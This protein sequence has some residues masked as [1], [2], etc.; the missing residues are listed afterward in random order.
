MDRR[1]SDRRASAINDLYVFDVQGLMQTLCRRKIL[2]IGI[3]L[4]LLA[5]ALTFVA[6]KPSQYRAVTSVIIE[7]PQLNPTEFQEALPTGRFDDLTI[8]TQVK[9]ISSPTIAHLT[10]DALSGK[11]VGADASDADKAERYK[12]LRTFLKHLTVTPIG[13][14]RVIEISYIS[15][16]PYDSAKSVNTHAEKYV[17]YQIANKKEQTKAINDWL[18]KQIETLRKESQVK[19]LAVQEYRKEAGIVLGKNSQDLI[20]RQ[21]TD[22]TEQLVPVETQKLTLQAQY[23]AMSA[24]GAK[25][26]VVQQESQLL[27]QLKANASAARQELKALGTKFG[28]SHPEILAAK[29]KVAQI[30][31][32][33]A[34]EK[35][36][37]KDSIALELD[38][39]IKQEALLRDRLEKLNQEADTLREK[40]IT[41]ESL[42]AEESANRKLLDNFLE[43]YEELKSQLDF[44][45]A[46]VHIVSPAEVPTESIGTPKS[47]LMAIIFVFVVIVSV[48]A[49]L[50]LELIDRGI[51]DSEEIKKILNLR[52]IGVLP[53]LKKKQEYSEE[54]KRVCLAL[55][56]RKS[57]QSVLFTA[58][59]TGEGVSTSVVAIAHYLAAIQR[60]VIII[61]ANSRDGS[62]ATLTGVNAAPGLAEIMSGGVDHAKAVQKDDH[63]VA[64]ISSGNNAYDLLASGRFENLLTALKSQYDFILI[65]SAPVNTTT[66]AEIIASLADQTIL[67]VESKKTSKATLKKAATALRQYAKDI[68]SVILNKQS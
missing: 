30:E 63:G 57:P 18:S 2:L 4:I 50:L 22:L 20:Y 54:I 41:L 68:P 6:L 24:S 23:D 15:K 42:E 45:R 11:T 14:S 38:A 61:D 51:E 53:K 16:D 26:D 46:D 5:P 59:S 62:I 60:R 36:N 66:D 21:I 48:G 1:T 19:F 17:E 35:K 58:A 65:D 31:S 32:D 47:I 33:I 34:R 44:S 43:R 10:L 27:Q 64:I 28:P 7:N 8:E 13:K 25:G 56:S 9:V 55:G 3:M 67:M 29:K 52:L 40:Q 39:A 49:V 12:D 37:G